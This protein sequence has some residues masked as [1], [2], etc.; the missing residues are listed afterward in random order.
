MQ[1][2]KQKPKN[3]S[4]QSIAELRTGLTETQNSVGEVMD[5][6]NV[7]TMNDVDSRI[8]EIYDVINS[9]VMVEEE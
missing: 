8:E 1:W 6:V 4:R 9:L 2:K 3:D 5:A 7:L